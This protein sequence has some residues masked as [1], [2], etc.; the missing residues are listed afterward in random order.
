[1]WDKL[2][3]TAF[4][5]RDLMDFSLLPVFPHMTIPSDSTSC[6][7][8]HYWQTRSNLPSSSEIRRRFV[9]MLESGYAGLRPAG[10]ISLAFDA[11]PELSQKRQAIA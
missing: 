4:S 8:I 1:M 3:F 7:A 2:N 9:F 6:N 11:L 10:R 5:N